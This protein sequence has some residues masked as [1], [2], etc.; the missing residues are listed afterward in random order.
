MRSLL[1][2]TFTWVPPTSI[3]SMILRELLDFGDFDIGFRS[4]W[5]RLSIS[6]T[7]HV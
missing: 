6:A 4:V 3:A 1:V 5:C 7:H 2:M